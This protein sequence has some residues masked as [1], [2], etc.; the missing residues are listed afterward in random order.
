MLLAGPAIENASAQV[1]T[2][3]YPV[4]TSGTPYYYNYRYRPYQ[5]YWYGPSYYYQGGTVVTPYGTYYTPYGGA[6]YRP[7]VYWY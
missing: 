1:W 4:Y 6:H 3:D 5:R 7:Y 2:Y